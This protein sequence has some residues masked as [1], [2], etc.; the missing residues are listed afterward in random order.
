MLW[1]ITDAREEAH[2]LGRSSFL[3]EHPGP[4]LLGL[5]M[6]PGNLIE[7]NSKRFSP[8]TG[9][10][11]RQ[12]MRFEMANV[13]EDGD[14]PE[15]DEQLS[16]V[17]K[18]TRHDDSPVAMHIGRLVDSHLTLADYS[19]SEHHAT[20]TLSPNL[21]S[22]QLIDHHSTNGTFLNEHRLRA[23]LAVDVDSGDQLRFG[24][25]RFRFLSAAGLY[26]LL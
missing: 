17:M 16:W 25:V 21:A 19:V 7:D 11:L 9:Q 2:R 1:E 4:V 12:T 14:R 15:A 6:R 18:L 10:P 3:A 13:L 26:E 5:A 24:R 8:T 20:M 23:Y 22:A